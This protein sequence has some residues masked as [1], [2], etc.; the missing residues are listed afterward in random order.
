MLNDDNNEDIWMF[1]KF[2]LKLCIFKKYRIP[3]RKY[4]GYIV[5]N[6][7]LGVYLT[8]FVFKQKVRFNFWISW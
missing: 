3:W 6:N 5:G 7:Q 8:V 4:L 1:W 2:F